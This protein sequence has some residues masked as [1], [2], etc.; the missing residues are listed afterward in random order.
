M[1]KSATSHLKGLA[2]S[3]RIA[4]F[5]TDRQATLMMEHAGW[6]RVA[7]NWARDEFRRAWFTG[8]GEPNEWLSDMDLRKRF[9]AVKRE[10][11]PWSR[12]LSQYVA[13]NAIIHMGL[14]LASWGEYCQARKQGRPHRKTGFPP[15]RKRHRKVAFT[16]SNGRNSI[17]VDGCSVHLPRIGWVRM[18]EELR[19]EGD[20]MG[21]TVSRKGGRWFASFTVDTCE[22][23][24]DP[25]PGPDIGIDMGVKTLVTVWD[26][27]VLE[28]IA[29]PKALTA[30]LKSLRRLDKAIARSI[31]THGKHNPS[32]RRDG[33]YAQRNRL[34]FDIAN[35]RADHHHKATTQI[36]KRGGTVKVETLNVDGMKRNRRLA[37]A[38]SDAGMA[39]FVRQLEY[40]CGWYGT[41]FEKV[42]RWYP[43]SKTCSACGAVKQSLL[44]SER[45]YR[46]NRCGFECDRDENAARNLQ[47]YTG[48]PEPARTLNALPL[49]ARSAGGEM[50]VETCR[51]HRREACARS[52]KR[53]PDNPSAIPTGNGGQV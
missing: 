45:T 36:A 32:Q 40:K 50:D 39:E 47:A 21:V 48:H 12:K 6:A 30:A 18:R 3:H 43:S 52:G 20:I 10:A 49:P 38:I 1:S 17:Q 26:G 51:T 53:L 27:D 44:L 4:L 31:H 24:P 8:E 16:P 28:E 37:R 42:D 46:C 34:H 25:K 33:L 7:A 19:F 22:P 29:N 5:P 2:K 11:F 13:K 14:G 15:V 41:A 23:A 35:L 9:N